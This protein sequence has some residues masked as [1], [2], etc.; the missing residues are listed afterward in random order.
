MKNVRYH[1]RRV[2]KYEAVREESDPDR[3]EFS[4]ESHRRRR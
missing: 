2:T 1:V 3:N 4:V